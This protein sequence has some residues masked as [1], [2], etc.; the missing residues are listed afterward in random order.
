[1]FHP[2]LRLLRAFAAVAAE[3][4]VTR[5]AKRLHL[6]QS[7]VSGQLRELEQAAGYPLFERTTRRIALTREGTRL[8]PFVQR[9]MNEVDGLSREVEAL[10]ASDQCHFRLGAAIY[11]M[12]IPERIALL[13]AFAA[14]LPQLSYAM[15]NRL[16]SAQIPD[17][18]NSRLDVSLLLG[19]A[20][21]RL[22]SVVGREVRAIVSENLYPDTLERIVLRRQAMHLLV[23]L[24]SPLAAQD[25][26]RPGDLRGLQVA[27]FNHAHGRALTAPIERFLL[28]HGVELI[29]PAEGNAMAVE[30]Y[31]ARRGICAIGIGWFAV[32]DGL[33][34]RPVEGMDFAMELAVVLGVGANHPARAFFDFAARW[35]AARGTTTS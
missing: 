23:P 28:D 18:I 1:M 8:L 34:A 15:D 7:T 22:D 6:T 11:G 29:V 20:V 26:I 25:E 5:A 30:R 17:L 2:D 21:P 10:R 13:D 14:A 35:Q 33:V 3:Q 12:D 32:P 4:S 24:A 9:I 19:I 16:Q 31:A 27:M